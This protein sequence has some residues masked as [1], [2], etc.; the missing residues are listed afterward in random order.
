MEGSELKYIGMPVGGIGCGQVN[1]GGDGRLWLWDIFNHIKLGVVNKTVVYRKQTLNPMSGSNY[2]EPPEQ[3]H[4][5]EQGFGLRLPDGTLRR[6]KSGDWSSIR[7]RGEYPIGTVEYDD[8]NSP[9]KVTL[10]A[11]SPF[12]PLQTERS[13]RP[14]TVM[15]FSL[16]NKT[17]VAMDVELLG[18]LENAV[19]AFTSNEPDL[20]KTSSFSKGAQHAILKMGLG[21]KSP[22]ADRPMIVFDDFERS[23]FS[24]WTVEGEAFGPGPIEISRMPGYQGVVGGLGKRIVCSH[25]SRDGRNVREA[26]SLTGRLISRDFKIERKWIGFLIAGGKHPDKTCVN[27][28]VDGKVVRTATGHDSN[29]LWDESFDVAEFEGKTGHIEIVDEVTEGWGNISVDHIVFTDVWPIP[30]FLE[31]RSD[32]GTIALSVLGSSGAAA[33]LK[34]SHPAEQL[35]GSELLLGNEASQPEQSGQRLIEGISVK[36]AVPGAGK[37]EVTFLVSWSFPNL[38][39]PLLG[40]VGN[41]PSM[42][43][44]DLDA[45][46]EEMAACDAERVATQLWHAVWYDSTLPRWLL[47]RTM[48]NSSTMATMT[49]TIFANGRFYGWEGVGCCAGTCGHVYQY[50]QAMAR[51]FPDLER[52]VRKMVDFGVAFHPDSGLIDFRGEYGEGYAVDSQAGYVLRALREHQMS[53]DSSFLKELW[54]RV[55]LALEFMM[56]QEGGA[57]GLIRNRQHNTLDIDMYGPSSW[58]SSL[59]L[60]AVRAGQEMAEELGDTAF[61]D[62]CASILKNGYEAMSRE[63]WNGEYFISKPAPNH[64]DSLIYGDGCEVDQV[65]GQWWCWQLGIKDRLFDGGQIKS[66]LGAIYKY[67]MLPDVGPFRDKFTPGRWYAMPG[68]GGLVIC[69][70]PRYDRDEV[71]GQNPV[72]SSMYFDECMTGFEY[73]AAGH[74]IAEGLVQEGLTAIKTVHER[75]DPSRRNPWNEVECSD[76]YARCMAVYGAFINACGFE[77]H[78]PKGHIGFDPRITPGGFRS[79]FTACSGW[80]TYSQKFAADHCQYAIWLKFGQLR[81]RTWS[82]RLPLGISPDALK[83]LVNGHQKG[84]NVKAASEGSDHGFVTVS[85]DSE[86]HLKAGD[87]LEAIAAIG[88]AGGAEV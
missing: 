83:I 25:N 55:R 20:L 18:W 57:E 61:R 60:A 51:L 71:L 70:F 23:T 22:K 64:P 10:E 28:V 68:E 3:I 84:A 19:G 87:R 32:V 72:W 41:L 16:E 13:T 29:A 85:F 24:G 75:Y 39:V 52:S 47:D 33:A 50:A 12:I 35:L 73:E 11:Y 4:P 7:F 43:W 30:E 21:V 88:F 15:R 76:H 1:L 56:G 54:P 66:A 79:A 77:H 82:L 63:L 53:E 69:T 65:M 27:L 49:S 36:A 37:S 38:E 34:A 8:P 58:L 42:R 59:Y 48:G 31:R 6:F 9:V 45:L 17:D 2:V 5:F 80:G 78:G 74:M 67:N 81:L 40:R 86:V 62:R 26:D 44:R 14:C 46:S